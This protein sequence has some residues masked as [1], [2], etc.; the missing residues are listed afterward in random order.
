MD[1]VKVLNKYG[2]VVDFNIMKIVRAAWAALRS[3]GYSRDDADAEAKVIADKVKDHIDEFGQRNSL[4]SYEVI[5]KYVE[6]ELMEV[7]KDAARSYI[8]YRNTRKQ[9]KNQLGDILGQIREISKETNKDNANTLLS[10][11]SKMAQI[12]EAVNKFYVLNQIVPP[13]IAEAHR[14]GKIYIH[15]LGFYQITYNCLNFA[16]SELLNDMKMPHGYLRRPKRIGTAFALAAIA[17]QSAANSQFG[18]IGINDVDHEMAE[19]ISDDT[20]DD[21]IY[22]ACEGFIGNLNTLHARSG[23]QVPFTSITLG[24]D[25]SEKAR[26]ITKGILNAYDAGLGHGEQPL[27]PNILFKVKTG[28][29]RYPGDPNYDLF[30]L[31]LKVTARRMFPTYINMDSSFNAPYGKEVSYMGCVAGQEVIT[32]RYKGIIYVEGIER[33]FRRLSA[34]FTTKI[35]G[36]SKWLDTDGTVEIYDSYSKSFVNCKK[37]ICNPN[38]DNWRL[39]TFSNGRSLIATEDHPLPVE[40]R[41]RVFVRDLKIGDCVPRTTQPSF[42]NTNVVADVDTDLAWL[43]GVMLCDGNYDRAPVVSL[44][45]DESDILAKYITTAKLLG[46]DV[47]VTEQQRGVKGHYFDA[48]MKLG[49]NLASTRTM[50][51]SLYNGR[52]KLERS[53]PTY[54][55]TAPEEVRAAFIA[56]MMD[57]DGFVSVG[58]RKHQPSVSCVLG[59]TNMELA[60]QQA[61][62]VESLGIPC[63]VHRN[64]YKG[65]ENC[66]KVRYLVH[67]EVDD[68]VIKYMV[69]NKKVSRATQL[70]RMSF[71]LDKPCAITA[72]SEYKSTGFSYDVETDS[73]HFDV[74]G[75]N[76]HNCRTRIASNVNGPEV[77]NGR[78]NIA[79]VTI[80]LPYLA[81]EAQGNVDTFFDKLHETMQLCER[82]LIHRYNILRNLRRKDVPMNMQGLWLNS[83]YRP[84]DETI[85]E[86]LK[87]GTLA[88]GY[89]GIYETL[90][91]L[92]GKGQHEDPAA[93]ELGLKIAKFMADY[94]KECTEK[95]HLNF[96]VIATPAESACHTLLKATRRA[97]GV[98]PHVTDKDYF[99][100]SC[101][102]AP[103]ARVTAEEKIKLEGPYHKYA[104]GGAILYLELGASPIGNIESIE[105]IVNEACDAD[106][107]YIA[108]NFP[109]DFC[110][111]CGHLGIIPLEGCQNCGSTDIRRVRRITGYFSSVQNFNLGKLSE[112]HDRTTH[113]GIPIGLDDLCEYGVIDLPTTTE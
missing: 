40:G 84:D 79:F 69:S 95:Y 18:G 55:F 104:L 65:K 2:K 47:A 80:N 61:A 39:L 81:L 73:D 88:F 46:A 67:F 100:N 11:A 93:Q 35:Y 20:T 10:P 90:M 113:L 74:S 30:K 111:N 107:G 51:N 99:V 14:S 48:R 70:P 23:N 75:L 49:R 3:A 112:L 87:N 24:M 38:K 71:V 15:D 85:E 102:V 16:V 66:D 91:E 53:I 28:V 13:D 31:A 29:N 54:V 32:Y 17:L 98:V 1:T 36:E 42:V 52:T 86:S 97:F 41:G 72:I 21:E 105:R 60:L 83:K 56:G 6:D 27:F 44:G 34:D 45:A 5:H 7:S 101:H 106:A 110:N 92:M 103:F 43:Y 22:Q 62:L 76:S 68:R 12:A 59:S 26:R 8:E 33:A 57:A 63:R 109:I 58:P 50:F 78:G 77:A 9:S 4:I 25:T 94:A 19:F 96:S 89:I 108:L 82:Q 37:F 64:H